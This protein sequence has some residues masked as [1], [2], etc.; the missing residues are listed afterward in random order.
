[1]GGHNRNRTWNRRWNGIETIIGSGYGIGD[2]T[3]TGI[4]ESFGVGSIIGVADRTGRLVGTGIGPETG[5]GIGARNVSARALPRD[6][7][8][9]NCAQRCEAMRAVAKRRDSDNNTTR[10][11]MLCYA[12]PCYVI[13]HYSIRFGSLKF[14]IIQFNSIACDATQCE[15]TPPTHPLTRPSPTNQPTHQLAT[16][17]HPATQSSIRPQAHPPVPHSPPSA[18]PNR[19]T[20][21]PANPPKQRR[22]LTLGRGWPSRP[23]SVRRAPSLGG[24][25]NTQ[26]RE[27][28]KASGRYSSR[29]SSRSTSTCG[30]KK[31]ISS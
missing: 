1:M 4:G 3:G 21:P 14:Y 16:P 31:E 27:P 15:A 29:K 25:S 13:R 23:T 11:S 18:L 7:D 5:I 30:R 12:T 28:Q 20:H 26:R 10:N 9:E 17:P 24:P 22:V 8:S 6:S 2:T 19:L